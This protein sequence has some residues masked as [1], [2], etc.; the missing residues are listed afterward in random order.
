MMAL[1]KGTSYQLVPGYDTTEKLSSL[2]AARMPRSL[3]WS[4]LITSL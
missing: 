1:A 4:F 2:I 3:L